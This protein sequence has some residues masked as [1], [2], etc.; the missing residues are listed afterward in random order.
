MPSP[1]AMVFA[2]TLQ[3]E[4]N[5]FVLGDSETV[6]GC[7]AIDP[8]NP[9]QF[10]R[11]NAVIGDSLIIV[12]GH[13]A[14]D[15]EV[16]RILRRV[17][18]WGVSAIWIG[19]SRFSEDGLAVSVTDQD[20]KSLEDSA[21]KLLLDPEKLVPQIVDCTDEV[22]VTCSDE[23]RIGEV[24]S[25]PSALFMPARVRTAAG[26]EDVDVTII[27]SVAPH[28]LL[29]IHAGGAI[30]LLDDSMPEVRT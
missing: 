26:I 18:A 24:I 20:L 28:D 29:L 1:A 11:E 25:S 16:F 15:A 8:N 9:E 6:G 3:L 14:S 4:R 12:E 30:A 5:V 17:P 7:I 19:R 21:R 13:G 2:R 22:C 10:L 23:G 27:G